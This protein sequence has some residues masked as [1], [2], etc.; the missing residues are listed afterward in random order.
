MIELIE[1]FLSEPNENVGSIHNERALQL[2]LGLFLRQ[3]G[4][5]V[6]F[7]KPCRVAPHPDQ[8]KRQKRYL[9]LFVEGAPTKL[10]IE[11]KCP[12]A[13]RVPETMYDFIA[14]IAFTEAILSN[15]ISTSAICLMMTNDS[16]FWSGRPYGIYEPFRS[17][18]T[19]SGRYQKPTGARSSQVFL[20]NRYELQWKPLGNTKLLKNAQY[21]LVEVFCT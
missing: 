13:G 6:E 21:L 11:L 2:E 3:Q 20:E 18:A 4:Y 15:N 17:D 12:F 16:A 19:L 8:T 7:E 10:A 9:D 5:D 1:K 14:D